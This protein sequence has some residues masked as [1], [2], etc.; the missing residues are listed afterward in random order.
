MR[1][2]SIPI[3]FADV[4]SIL[5]SHYN[6]FD[7]KNE[8]KILF[9]S[10]NEWFKNNLLSLNIS[11]TQLV[12]FTT[13]NTNQIEIA[14]DYNNTTIPISSSTKFLGLTVDCTLSWS[15]YIALIT[16]KTE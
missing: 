1:K 13:R 12:N 8:I 14:I 15:D 4:T 10:L 11:K 9:I 3:L 5:I 16:K 6:L 2:K 7:F